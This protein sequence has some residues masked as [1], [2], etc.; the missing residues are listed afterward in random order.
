MPSAGPWANRAKER[1]CKRCFKPFLPTSPNHFMCGSPY[2]KKSCSYITILRK[3]I[4]WHR[5]KSLLLQPHALGRICRSC[6]HLRFLHKKKSHCMFGDG[7][8]CPCV[9][10]KINLGIKSPHAKLD[11]QKV[12]EIRSLAIIK[13]HEFISKVYGVNRTTISKILR[14]ERWAHVL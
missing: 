6:R 3:R 13:T 14:G 4:N 8:K 9:A 2:D 1:I 7:K 10:H 12:K 11:D 5:R